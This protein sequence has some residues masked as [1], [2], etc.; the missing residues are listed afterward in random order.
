MYST[1]SPPTLVVLFKGDFAVNPPH[2][3]SH[4]VSM[5]VEKACFNYFLFLLCVSIDR[6]GTMT[7]DWNEWRDH[8]LFNPLHNMEDIAHHWKHSLVDFQLFSEIRL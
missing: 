5:G 2:V 1:H 3:E 6:D 7:I 4:I 8:F